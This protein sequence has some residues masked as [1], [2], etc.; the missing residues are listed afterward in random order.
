MKAIMKGIPKRIVIAVAVLLV[1]IAVAHLSA[2]TLGRYTTTF[3]R[4]VGF[5]AK[6]KDTAYVLGTPSGTALAADGQGISYGWSR[7][8][9]SGE[10]S[11][12]VVVSNS[13]NG[14]DLPEDDLYVT[15]RVFIPRS[16]LE[17]G[18]L[19]PELIIEGMVGTPTRL[20]QGTA[21]YNSYGDGYVYRVFE[22][23]HEATFKLERKEAE[24]TVI[25]EMI[26]EDLSVNAE[27]NKVIV[28]TV[29]TSGG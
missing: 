14:I 1:L 16:E 8:E 4:E 5:S 28:E 7:N 27:K 24:S 11:L 2:D 13:P 26:L 15:L 21:M 25:L 9:I 3:G 23:G 17:N 18:D 20:T 22:D 29:H 10:Q 12:S 6:G 19:P